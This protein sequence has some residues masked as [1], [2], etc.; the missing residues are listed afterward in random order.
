[1]A[2]VDAIIALARTLNLRSIA[3]GI[4]TREQLAYL[5]GRG[6]DLMQGYYFDRPLYP[7]DVPDAVRR[8]YS[9]EIARARGERKEA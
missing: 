7:E 9:R 8:D 2:I 5:A 6:C 1:V 4:E 3:E